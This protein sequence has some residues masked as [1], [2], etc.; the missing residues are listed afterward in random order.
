MGGEGAADGF[1]PGLP[2]I[3]AADLW[4]GCGDHQQRQIVR[5]GKY[6]PRPRRIVMD[7]SLHAFVQNGIADCLDHVAVVVGTAQTLCGE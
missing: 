5:P 3:G 2:V 4:L 6:A 1:K 7:V